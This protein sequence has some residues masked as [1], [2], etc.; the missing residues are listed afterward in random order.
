MKQGKLVNMSALLLPLVTVACFQSPPSSQILHR[1]TADAAVNQSLLPAAQE[2]EVADPREPSMK[3][4]RFAQ[5]HARRF[6]LDW[7]LVV[8]VMNR[9]SSFRHT[10]RSKKGAYG[11]M[12]IMPVTSAEIV[13]KLG[14]GETASPSNNVK[15]GAFYLTRLSKNFSQADGDDQ[16]KLTLAAYNAGLTRI[17]DAQDLARFFGEDPQS[18]ETIRSYLPLLSKRYTGVHEQV[19]KT[20]KPRGGYFRNPSETIRYVDKVLQSYD[21]YSLALR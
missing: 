16:L 21:H 14:M 13:E 17:R 2:V 8:A 10:A 11:L 7:T 4:A 12:Q 18:W 1:T 19:W 3:Y 15:A 6:G 20:G 9:E 5:R